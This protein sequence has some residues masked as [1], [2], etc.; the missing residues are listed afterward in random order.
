M[1]AHYGNR[2]PTRQ[3][4]FLFDASNKNSYPGSGTTWYNIGTDPNNAN[5]I[6][7]PTHQAT[8]SDPNGGLYFQ[9]D[10][11]GPG[12]T[13]DRMHTSNTNIIGSQTFSVFFQ[14]SG[15][16]RSPAGILTSHTYQAPANIGINHIGGNKLGAS[17]GYTD[18]TR[19]YATKQ[20]S[21]TLTQGID[22]HASLVY[23]SS[24]NTIQYYLNGLPDGSHS[25]GSKTVANADVPITLG[26]WDA[27]YGDYYF[28]GRI[29]WAAVHNVALTSKEVH[30]MFLNLNHR[31]KEF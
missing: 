6:N 15:G 17:I 18:G 21:T 13:Q 11:G 2:I 8:N 1:P 27:Y 24:D 22:Y 3:L 25:L 26:R 30:S 9:F 28:N 5:I 16:P 14:I 29:Y 10:G 12:T 31:F 19:E 20:N 23:D 4:R 7:S